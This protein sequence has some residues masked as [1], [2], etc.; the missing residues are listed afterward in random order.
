ML[1]GMLLGL[2]GQGASAAL[3]AARQRRAQR[4][5]RRLAAEE[6]AALPAFDPRGAADTRD[7]RSGFLS[8]LP[9]LIRRPEPLPEPELV[10]PVAIAGDAAMPGDDRIRAR[11]ADVIRTRRQADTP[12]EADKPLT[13]GL[14]RRPDPLI[15]DPV[16]AGAPRIEPPLTGAAYAAQPE[17]DDP[18]EDEDALEEDALPLQ[19][20]ASDLPPLSGQSRARWCR[21][22]RA[23]PRRRR[24]GRRPR[25]SLGSISTPRAPG[26]SCRRSAC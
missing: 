18:F 12:P 15:L 21:T 26:S 19:P 1:Y 4:A 3:E 17:A 16:R 9:S 7:G 5:E 11:I 10:E 20:P 24:A 13:R 6:A 23:R 8:R 14:G 25:R 22:R 2:L